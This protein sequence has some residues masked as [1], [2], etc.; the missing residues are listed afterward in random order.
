MSNLAL[1][2]K[3]RSADFSEV[4]GQQHVVQ[5]LQNAISSGKH[6]H[7][8]LL[9]GPRGV[10]KTSIA[11]IIAKQLNGLSKDDS[12]SDNLDIIEIDGAS[13]RGI[14]EIRSLREKIALAPAKLKYKVY[15]IDEVHML[16]KEAFNALLKTLEEPPAHVVF[17]FAT[18]EVQ[19][20][21][22]TIISR[23]QRFDF[24]P[25]KLSDMQKHL[26][27]IAKQEAID[28]DS[29]AI[30]LIA[31]IS[32]GGFRDAIGMLDQIS[33]VKGT[34]SV[35]TISEF[36]GLQDINK[37]EEIFNARQAKD[38][39]QV[40]H[41]LKGLFDDGADASIITQQMLDLVQLYLEDGESKYQL[42]FLI[43]L[44][45]QLHWVQAGLKSTTVPQLLLQTGLA[46]NPQPVIT[47]KAPA[48][49]PSQDA[50]QT[51]K[52]ANT[53]PADKK[54]NKAV[55]DN[56]D[57]RMVKSLSVI[58]HYNNSLYAVL[59]G[60]QLAVNDDEISIACRFSFHRERLAEPRN[61]TLI[62]KAFSKVYGKSMHVKTSID[63]AGDTAKVDTDQELMSSA[64]AILGGEVIDG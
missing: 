47:A 34:I 18:T 7:A 27:Y 16:T 54:T 11:R 40:I 30:E 58:K 33:A 52:S 51:A 12:L 55:A 14:D 13:N 35:A 9:T 22:E 44:A 20:L 23:T 39:K 64:M 1:Y 10:G 61:Q 6:S 62:E 42:E 60:S 50:K 24:R 49:I 56:D 37:L 3:Y 28:I 57:S 46:R 41:L 21:P 31:R 38:T 59:R 5:T 45:E 26:S 15:I 8:Y 36:T 29:E 63:S 25:I 43:E 2:R 53:A 19:K 32:R 4:V 48:D 17:I